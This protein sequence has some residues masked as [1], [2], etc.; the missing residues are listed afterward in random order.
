MI[1]LICAT[2]TAGNIAIYVVLIFMLI[3]C[4]LASIISIA[5]I[6]APRVNI[7]ALS[8]TIDLLLFVS[9]CAVVIV[10]ICIG[11]K[12]SARNKQSHRK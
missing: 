5:E 4:M 12:L 6:R 9:I 1:N 11:V 3:F 8:V 10:A 2:N 7:L